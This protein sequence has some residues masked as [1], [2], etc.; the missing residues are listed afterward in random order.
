MNFQ[1]YL[2]EAVSP[3]T[4][5]KAAI[6]L[7]LVKP[8]KKQITEKIKSNFDDKGKDLFFVELE[9]VDSD[10]AVI[11]LATIFTVTGGRQYKS[12]WYFPVCLKVKIDLNDWKVSGIEQC[13][14]HFPE[15][16]VDD[17]EY[18]SI[19]DLIEFMNSKYDLIKF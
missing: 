11:H 19:P 1:N 16:T 7:T 2:S 8:I 6:A 3:K 12:T 13:D 10:S 17:Q 9:K 18:T 14:K 4:D 5:A 15:G